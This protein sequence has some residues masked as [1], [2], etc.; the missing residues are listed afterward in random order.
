MRIHWILIATLLCVASGCT[1]PEPPAP[2]L[3]SVAT[4][5][6]LMASMIDP[7]ADFLF[8]TIVVIVD[9]K[10]IIDKTPKTDEEWKEVRRH[11]L[12]LLEAPNLLISAGRRV[13]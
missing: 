4:L 1:R 11:A 5:R 7:S 6:E 12:I 9:E 13:A 2:E 10:G 8:E 3:S